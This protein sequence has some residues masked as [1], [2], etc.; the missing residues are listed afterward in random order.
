MEA[1]FISAVRNAPPA[2]RKWAVSVANAAAWRS[3]GADQQNGRKVRTPLFDKV[4]TYKVHIQRRLSRV[5]V[6]GRGGTWWWI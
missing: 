6:F 1:Y 2:S 3:E 5:V 4:I